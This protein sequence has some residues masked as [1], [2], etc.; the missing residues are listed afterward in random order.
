MPQSNETVAQALRQR[1]R[2]EVLADERTLTRYATDMSMY[3]IRP[4]AV[5]VPQDLEDVTTV[6]N[7]AREER[8]PITPRA[9]GTSTA[10]SALGRGIVLGFRRSGPMNDIL[11]FDKVAG[12][13]QVTV[14]PALLHDE[15][16]R[17]LRERG[18]YL[19][20]DPSSGAVCLM[21]GNIAT[22]ASGPHALKHGSIDRYLHHVQFVTA[23]GE[24]VDTADEESIPL[25]I[26][27]GV[28]AL[29]DDVLADELTV[30]R[31]DTRKDMKLASG[32]N[33]FTFL[34]H[35]QAGDLVA[36]LLVGSVGSLGVVTRATLR[37][38]PYVEGKAT[39]L[40]Y[41]RN[42]HEAGDAVQHIKALNVAAIEIMNHSA[43]EVVRRRHPDLDIPDGKVQVL[44]VEFEG[45]ERHD[46]IAQVEKLV[47]ENGYQL[48]GPLYTA[49][50]EA[51]QARLWKA[52]KSLLPAVRNYR[53]P[54]KALSLVNDVGVD[55]A[56]LADFILDVE[57]VLAR[58]D[59]I[60]AIY[61]HAGSG[62]LHLR[63]LF[64][65]SD[66]DLPTLLTQVAD[67]VYET[68]FRYDG[69][70]TAEHGM[71]RLRVPYLAREWGEMITG[72]MRRVK[73]IF[74]PDDLLNPE[75]MFGAR[76]LTDDLKLTG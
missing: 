17:F 10:G 18:L 12:E 29:R 72:Y 40:L 30:Q 69:T 28:L 64:D 54:L 61:G 31:L 27:A 52:R 13:P 5:V 47:Q 48:A 2:G 53:P 65:V 7:F 32:Y 8:I 62:N 66:P 44:L 21:G 76:A 59:L 14:E 73:D 41:F 23:E 56:H 19:P 70:I 16:Q 39:T 9:G 75:V 63:P 43:I 11:H 49:T 26:R 37:A 3:E 60:A 51:E 67:E 74:D 25:R 4:L 24:V 45:A 22:K 71:G 58:H 46:Q 42:L 36:Q 50:D 55:V 35:Q 6:V 34:R 33:L 68:V 1:M 57:A 20:A 38:E 15:L